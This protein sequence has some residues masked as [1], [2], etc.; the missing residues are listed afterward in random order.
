[1]TGPPWS[2]TSAGGKALPDEVIAQIV[3][4]TDGVP[5]FVEELTKSVLESGLLR[6]EEIAMCS[7]ARCR[8]LRSR[9]VCM[10]H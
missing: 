7:I 2:S 3:D 6:E 9:Q 5:L 10:T 8:H 1:M 4:R